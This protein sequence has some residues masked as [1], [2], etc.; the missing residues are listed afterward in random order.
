MCSLTPLHLARNLPHNRRDRINLMPLLDD[1]VLHG[2]VYYETR[3]LPSKQITSIRAQLSAFWWKVIYVGRD[4]STG[5]LA[6][7]ALW[8][9]M[10]ATV[11]VVNRCSKASAVL[12]WFPFAWLT[13]GLAFTFEVMRLNESSNF[14]GGL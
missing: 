9:Y 7:L 8:I 13:L 2:K 11:T 14:V 6:G 3:D 10:L 1:S 12:L 5:F 4:V